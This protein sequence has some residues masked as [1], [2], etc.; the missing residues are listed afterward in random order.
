[1]SE[2]TKVVIGIDPGKTGGAVALNLDGEAL[3]WMAADHPG[4]G[5]TVRGGKGSAGYVPS[6]MALWLYDM[7][8]AYKVI[9]VVVEHQAARPLEGRSSVFTTGYGFGLWVG[10]LAALRFRYLVAK[11]AVW[12]REIF[13]SKPKTAERKARAITTVSAQVPTLSLTWG[14]K[15]KPHDGLADAA[16]LALYGLGKLPKA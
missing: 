15:K 11:P 7:S 14:R 2:K 9:L 10:M 12:T 8:E 6:C 3:E 13:G 4:E 16:C 1:M 5:Y